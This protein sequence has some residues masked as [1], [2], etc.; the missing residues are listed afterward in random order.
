MARCKYPGCEHEED[1]RPYARSGIPSATEVIGFGF[2]DK[3]LKNR[4]PPDDPRHGTTNA[5]QNYACRCRRCLAAQ[6][7]DHRS[8]QSGTRWPRTVK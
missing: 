5:Y 3:G 8:V 7:D 4:L 2:G 6:V 1:A